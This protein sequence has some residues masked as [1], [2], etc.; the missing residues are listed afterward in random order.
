MFGPNTISSTISNLNYCHRD[1]EFFQL[2][3]DLKQSFSNLFNMHDYEIIFLPGSG[4]IG[5]EA[6]MFSIKNNLKII[7]IDGKFKNRWKKMSKLYN[8]ES[9]TMYEELFCQLETSNSRTFYKEDCIVD[10][11]SS[12]PYYDIPSGTKVFITSSNKILGSIPGIAIVGIRSDFIT[13][14]KSIDHTSYLNL[15][16]YINYSKINQT[17]STAP[18]QI[19][20]HLNEVLKN[21]STLEIIDKININS[22]KIVDH[23][24]EDNIIGEYPCPVITISKKNI[25]IDI[26]N[27]FQLYHV[28]DSS[29][30][31]QIFTYSE[32]LDMYDAFLKSLQ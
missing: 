29:E 20:N 15:S 9:N 22:A 26:A 10:A 5:I 19:L 3:E 2:F 1:K 28:N 13:E 27:K 18:I 16:R 7:G 32:D 17:P 11:I 12:F 14:L 4:T 21:F 31:Y 30:N 24:G 25:P 6:V 8:D 23:F